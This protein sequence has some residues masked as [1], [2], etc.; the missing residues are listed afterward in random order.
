M[1]TIL[2]VGHKGNMGRRYAAILDYL[3]Y[4]WIGF[5]VDTPE[6]LWRKYVDEVD[7]Y[8]V[9]TPT[10]T[11][12]TIIENLFK[13]Q[14]PI[15]SEKPLTTKMHLLE[16]F[17][18][19]NRIEMPWLAVVNQYKYLDNSQ[20]KGSTFYNYFKTGGDGLA[21]DCVS[22]FGVAR[23]IVRL[24]NTSPIWV[25]TLNGRKIS[26]ASMDSAYVEMLEDW[27]TKPESNYVTARKAH[28][29]AAEYESLNMKTLEHQ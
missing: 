26:L 5:D 11:H 17:E 16:Q 10:A 3:G 18:D 19:K 13:N 9:A 8:I 2:I 4:K 15:L 20:S 24:K 12:L 23:G 14:K 1:K 29:K 21:F 25:C 6:I 22:L 7:G 28:E 27:I